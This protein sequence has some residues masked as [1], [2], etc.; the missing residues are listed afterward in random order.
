MEQFIKH[1]VRVGPG[2][3]VCTRD[4]QYT[5]ATGYTVRVTVGAKFEPGSILS[6]WLDEQ[7]EKDENRK[8][9]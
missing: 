1:F 6:M 5:S 3:W 2:K 4:G 9:R 8:A 7:Y